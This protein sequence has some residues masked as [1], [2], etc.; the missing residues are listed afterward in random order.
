G[1]APAGRRPFLQLIAWRR[2][3][4]RRGRW[5]LATAGPRRGPAPHRRPDPAIPRR[6]ANQ[7]AVRAGSARTRRPARCPR[8]LRTGWRL[9]AAVRWGLWSEGPAAIRARRRHRGPAR[10][11]VGR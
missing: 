4:V 2:A 6:T 5:A 10:P 11:P 9:A 1:E 3:P 8:S 7:R